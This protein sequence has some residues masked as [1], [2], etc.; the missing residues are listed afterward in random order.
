[1]LSLP[2]LLN[3]DNVG[4]V[5]LYSR[6]R[7]A[8]DA[9]VIHAVQLF[10]QPAVRHLLRAHDAVSGVRARTEDSWMTI[11]HALGVLMWDREDASVDAAR[12]RLSQ[13]ACVLGL[14]LS[15][16]AARVIAQSLEPARDV[17]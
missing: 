16:T 14:T 17:T 10:L 4:S 13:M 3:D 15:Q 9:A 6:T 12:Q 8:F 7:Q 11:D 5:S 2:L 1:V